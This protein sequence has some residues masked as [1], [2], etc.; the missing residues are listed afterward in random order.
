[1][2]KID[3]ANLHVMNKFAKNYV[4]NSPDA[5]ATFF[6]RQSLQIM[7]WS[8]VEAEAGTKKMKQMSGFNDLI[9]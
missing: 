7:L 8:W 2:L 5:S 3:G 4:E 9:T 6:A 1:M